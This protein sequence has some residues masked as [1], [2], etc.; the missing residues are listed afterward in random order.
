M[1]GTRRPCRPTR[2]SRTHRF[3]QQ[4]DQLLF[5]CR[6]IGKLRAAGLSNDQ[7]SAV[8]GQSMLKA[9]AQPIGLARSE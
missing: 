1:C 7:Q 6:A 8:A 3:T 5:G 9:L 4:A 2:S